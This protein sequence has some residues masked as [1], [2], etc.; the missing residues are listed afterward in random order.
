MNKN[1]HLPCREWMNDS[2]KFIQILSGG[3]AP[4]FLLLG[5]SLLQKQMHKVFWGPKTSSIII[6]NYCSFIIQSSVS[7]YFPESCSGH[8]IIFQFKLYVLSAG[9]LSYSKKAT[10]AKHKYKIKLKREL[11]AGL[12]GLWRSGK[13]TLWQCSARSWSVTAMLGV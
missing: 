13:T 11:A 4:L 3:S 2:C 9:A 5:M 10:W 8:M 7:L 1:R 12:H 6:N